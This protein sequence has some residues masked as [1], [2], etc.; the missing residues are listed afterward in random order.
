VIVEI[1]AGLEE[2]HSKS[3]IHRDIKPHN[4]FVM[5]SGMSKVADFGISNNIGNTINYVK[6]MC[7]TPIYMAPEILNNEL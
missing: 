4:I 1:S 7:G 2:M 6:T 3:L 5:E